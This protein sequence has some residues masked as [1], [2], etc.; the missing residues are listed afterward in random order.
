MKFL[1]IAAALAALVGA[2]AVGCGPKQAY[3][4]TVSTGQCIEQDAGVG[5]GGEDT[6]IGESIIIGGDT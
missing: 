5:P 1:M 3:C 6:G 2:V 4:P